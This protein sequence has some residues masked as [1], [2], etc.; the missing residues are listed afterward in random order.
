MRSGL[1]LLGILALWA[2]VCAFQSPDPAAPGRPDQH[3]LIRNDGKFVHNVGQL[4]LQ[5]SNYGVTGAPFYGAFSN[6]PG[7]P[8]QRK[9]RSPCASRLRR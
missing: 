2:S 1:S 3:L 8:C 4:L 9:A 6:V 7:L 5:I